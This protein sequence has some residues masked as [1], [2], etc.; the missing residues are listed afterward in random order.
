MNVE[1]I[2]LMTIPNNPLEAPLIDP[3]YLSTEQDKWELRQCVR[4]SREIFAQNAFNEFRG[5]EVAPGSEV[6]SDKELDEFIRDQ[7]DTDYHPA[8]TCKMGSGSDPMAV[9]DHQAKVLGLENIRIVDA[10]IMPSN[11]SGNLNAPT[12]MMAEKLADVIMNKEQLKPDIDV[13]VFVSDIDNQ[14]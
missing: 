14:R 11:I 4:L 10:S 2:T 6:Q 9:V 8:C 5:R 3:N 1:Q 7:S 12:I 13:P